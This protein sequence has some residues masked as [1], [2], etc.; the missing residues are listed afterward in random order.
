VGEGKQMA[1]A[2]KTYRKPCDGRS[3]KPGFYSHYRPHLTPTKSLLRKLVGRAERP[4]G[5][6]S[7]LIKREML[8]LTHSFMMPI[9]RYLSTLMPLPRQLNSV[10]QAP[11]RL[12]Q[13]NVEEFI[14]TG[15]D[16]NG[17]AL[18][19]NVRGDWLS[20]YRR[21]LSS[22]NFDCWLR[23]RKRDLEG[24][25]SLRYLDLLCSADLSSAVIQMRHQVEIVDLVLRLKDRIASVETDAVRREKLQSQ[26]ATVMAGVDEELK[27]VLFSNGILSDHLIL[28]QR[29][30]LP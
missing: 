27:S 11:P 12:R 6:Q 16:S 18:T 20:L 10:F 21:F 5:V 29:T 14:K 17:P 7:T 3:T 30:Q 24:Q 2:Q 23:E 15:L 25:L 4:V 9:E 28:Q 13:F 19:S 1:M 8:E 26:L 22:R